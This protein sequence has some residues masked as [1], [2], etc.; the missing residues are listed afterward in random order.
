LSTQAPAHPAPQSDAARWHFSVLGWG[1]LGFALIAAFIPFHGV[2]GNLFDVWNLQP[3][4]SHGILIPLISLFLIW[5][6]RD[7][8]TRTPFQG[9]WAGIAL[10]SG[11]V[12]AWYVAELS[13]IWV[14][15]QYAF[16][17]VLY[18]LV[19]ALVGPRTFR[20]LWVPLLIL[21]FMIP[22]PA[23]FSN[24]LSLN[25]QLLSSAIG[26]AVIRLFGISVYLDGNVI[27]LGSYKLQVVEAC[28]GLRYLYPLMTLAF[29]VAYFF[30]APLWKRVILFLASI[31][32]AI[33]MNSLRIGLI[34]VAVEYWGTKMA[35][36]V[37]HDFE[38]WVV[39]MISTGVLLVL[40]AV[41]AKTGR[42]AARLRDV[43][44]LDLGPSLAKTGV[45][46]FRTLPRSFLAA[47][48]LAAMTAVVAFTMPERV[49]I[50][51]NRTSFI[52]FPLQLDSWHGRRSPL[53]SEYLDQLKLDDY[54][55]A[56]FGRPAGLPVNLWI[57]Y[58]DSQRKG[59]SAHSP[60]SCL[61]GG[62]WDFT[63]FGEHAVSTPGGTVT[64]NRAVIAHGAERQL[65][66]FWFQ[67][68]GR[69]VT[70]EYL[71]K[72]FIFRDAVTRNRT[73]GALVRLIV[74]IPP[75]SSEADADRELT[76][77]VRLLSSRLSHYVPD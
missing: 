64:V 49:E 34:G 41:L 30:R 46:K 26:V 1:V 63:S 13:T 3:E 19:L 73:D 74:P 12:L 23:F 52:D 4:Y 65:M 35:E 8:L 56:D 16:L 68:R 70:N 18:G 48:A 53:E 44:M 20:Q 6:E 50:R 45:N 77:F 58:Y 24:S 5:R 51:P 10:V 60:R 39:F 7:L 14:I 40:A 36:G 22:L 27:D 25:L 71:V 67:Q 76:Q 21:L 33:L 37:L 54:L 61:P 17:L 57:A 15:G 38:G 59:Q 55:L 2:L 42:P 75:Q 62:G 43:L 47:T 72:W 69:V 32:V 11:G 29:I 28:S 9:S 31:P 66:Y